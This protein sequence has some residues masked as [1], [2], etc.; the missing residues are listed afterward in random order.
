MKNGDVQ[1]LDCDYF[2]ISE[3]VKDLRKDVENLT[4][5]VQHQNAILQELVRTNSLSSKS[6]TRKVEG[7]L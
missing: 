5:T 7:R 2:T 6:D 3:E 4:L 1:L